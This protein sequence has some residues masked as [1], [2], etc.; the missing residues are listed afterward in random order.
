M[1]RDDFFSPQQRQLCSILRYKHLYINT[2]QS[3]IFKVPVME[4][5]HRALIEKQ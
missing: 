2:I 5:V 1:H 3:V 4:N